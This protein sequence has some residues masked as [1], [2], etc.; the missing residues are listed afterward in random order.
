[1]GFYLLFTIPL[2]PLLSGMLS[3]DATGELQVLGVDGDALGV[4]GAEVGV[5][6]EA[7]EVGLG[8]LLEGEDGVALE[9][10]VGLEVL[11]DLTDETLEGKLADEKLSAPLVL[12]NLL[13]GD[14][15]WAVAPL[16][17]LLRL[18]YAAATVS[19]LHSCV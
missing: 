5:L 3:A 17:L 16:P 19:C 6:K 12:A 14:R 10:E 18:L 2:L 15:A 9:A 7:D 11:G 13:E 4:N 1:M 8:R